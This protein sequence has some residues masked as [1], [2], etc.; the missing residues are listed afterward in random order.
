MTI[1]KTTAERIADTKVKIEQYEAQMKDLLQ[2]QKLQE[3]KD[4][5]HRLCERGGIVEKLLPGLIRLTP[6]QFDTFVQEVLLTPFTKRVLDR[7]APPAEQ[8]NGGDTAQS[9]EAAAPEPTTPPPSG[10]TGIVQTTANSAVPGA[11]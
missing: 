2:K 10:G 1:R 4:R 7:L 11:S 3:K 9:G 5:T 8:Q 6:E